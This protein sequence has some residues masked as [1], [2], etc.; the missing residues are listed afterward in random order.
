MA[1]EIKDNEGTL[2]Y[3]SYRKEGTKQP[4]HKGKIKI[5]GV[6]YVLSAWENEGRNGPWWSIKCA[7][8]G[9][10]KNKEKREEPAGN[11]KSDDVDDEIPF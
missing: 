6:T 1:Y 11:T 3:N 8:D 4:T 7:E 5:K 2:S 10:W 9:A